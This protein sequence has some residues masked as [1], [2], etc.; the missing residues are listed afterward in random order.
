M[1]CS[2]QAI[3][4]KSFKYDTTDKILKLKKSR[5]IITLLISNYCLLALSFPVLLKPHQSAN[6]SYKEADWQYQ[7]GSYT[8]GRVINDV[9]QNLTKIFVVNKYGFIVCKRSA[10]KKLNKYKKLE[11]SLR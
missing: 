9:C 2:L 4:K 11:I 1:S 6:T 7:P 10:S 3:Q 5:F 8:V